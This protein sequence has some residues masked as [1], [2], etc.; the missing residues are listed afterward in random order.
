MLLL[1][2]AISFMLIQSRWLG[3]LSRWYKP[4]VIHRSAMVEVALFLYTLY[5]LLCF[6]FVFVCLGAFFFC[7]VCFFLNTKFKWWCW[8]TLHT[9]LTVAFKEV[10]FLLSFPLLHLITQPKWI[11][12]VSDIPKN[13]TSRHLPS[14]SNL[15][16]VLTA[17][18]LTQY[19]Q[20]GNL[21]TK[22]PSTHS[23]SHKNHE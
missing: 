7:F 4:G 9:P 19:L 20:E 18:I 12:N 3:L 21:R 1:Q 6:C 17:Y 11:E 14:R 13:K 22:E 8:K 2:N 10:P 15:V 23:H 16:V 5:V